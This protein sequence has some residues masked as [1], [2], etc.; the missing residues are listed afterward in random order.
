MG[1]QCNEAI[2][3]TSYNDKNCISKNNFLKRKLI[4]I[5]SFSKVKNINYIYHFLYYAFLYLGMGS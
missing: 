2:R 4:G 3:V 1:I 5:G